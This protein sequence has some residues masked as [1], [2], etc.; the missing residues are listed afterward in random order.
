MKRTARIGSALL[1]AATMLLGCGDDG[2]P[3][4]PASPE[5]AEASPARVDIAAQ[6]FSF[7]APATMNG[8]LVEFAFINRGKEPH[9]FGLAKIA[10]GKSFDDVK[11]AMSA[12][13]SATLPPGPPPFQDYAGIAT[14]DPGLGGEAAFNIPAGSYVFFC[15]I[16]SPDG[17]SHAAKGMVQPVT[18]TEGTEGALAEADDT[19]IGTD[20]AFDKNPALKAGSNVLR[21]RNEGRQLH[22]INLIELSEGKTVDDVVAWVRQPAGP[23][24]ARFLGGVAIVP[25]EEANT[26]LDV[27]EGRT[28]AYICAIPDVLGDFAPHITKGMLTQSVTVS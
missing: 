27:S 26:T 11:A 15:A 9:F 24:P 12:P 20:F 4:A 16:P 10:E 14:T 19:V 13:P 23:P 28:Y 7:D 21:I 18:V 3:S 1:V 8:G 25:G 17:V 6:D 2:E 5:E 22:E